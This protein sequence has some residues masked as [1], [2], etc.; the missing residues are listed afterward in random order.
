MNPRRRSGFLDLCKSRDQRVVHAKTADLKI[1]ECAQRLKS[2]SSGTRKLWSKNLPLLDQRE[3][4]L[5]YSQITQILCNLWNLWINP[6]YAG[7]MAGASLL[8]NRRGRLTGVKRLNR[9]SCLTGGG[10]ATT[11]CASSSCNVF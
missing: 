1:L 10:N 8:L 4:K 3:H 6:S 7:G 2:T 9:L 5:I 11:G